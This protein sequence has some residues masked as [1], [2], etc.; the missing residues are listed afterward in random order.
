M[1]GIVFIRK[2]WDWTAADVADRMGIH[3]TAVSAWERNNHIPAKRLNALSEVFYGLDAKYFSKELTE[4][5]K[6]NIQHF[7]T[8]KNL[9]KCQEEYEENTPDEFQTQSVYFCHSKEAQDHIFETKRF[10]YELMNE[11]TPAADYND[12]GEQEYRLELYKTIFEAEKSRYARQLLRTFLSV[13]ECVKK[14]EKP[15][16]EFEIELYNAIYKKRSA[17]QKETQML[18]QFMPINNKDVDENDN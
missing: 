12:L 9:N 16:D 4:V 6:L 7:K 13:Y 10:L 8:M 1:L 17:D 18:L 15:R 2:L 14:E 5:D 11:L 3:R